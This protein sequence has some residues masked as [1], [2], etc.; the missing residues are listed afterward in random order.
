M[1][2]NAL[3]H[4]LMSR[5]RSAL[6]ARRGL[7]GNVDRLD[8][9]RAAGWVADQR[10][11][12]P[13]ELCLLVD[14]MPVASFR[15]ALAR[16]DVRAAGLAAGNCGFDQP[17]PDSLRD[18]R[19]HLVEIRVGPRG[20]LLPGGSLRVGTAAT[21]TAAATG[22]R[23]AIDWLSAD[24]VVGWVDAGTGTPA[25]VRLLIDGQPALTARADQPRDDVANSG[26]GG[27]ISGFAFTMPPAF[28]D[29]QPH[30]V[31]VIE[32]ETGQRLRGGKARLG[33]PFEGVA[34]FDP[35][36]RAIAGWAAG[37]LAVRVGF[38]DGPAQ[39]VPLNRE[40]PGFADGNRLGF[41][42]ELPETLADGMVH[43]ARV[44]FGSTP[45][46]LDGAPV[47]FR[48]LAGLPRV[49][50][51]RVDGRRAELRLTDARGRPVA[52]PVAIEVDGE[53]HSRAMAELS[54]PLVVALP[55][56]AT[57]LDLIEDAPD[58]R[59]S[60]AR[61]RIEERGGVAVLTPERDPAQALAADALDP[62]LCAAAAEALA[63]FGAD[64]GPRFDAGWYARRW[65]QA[66][67]QAGS[68]SPAALLAH[69]L[70][71]GGRDGLS[72]G[73]WFDE[74][75]ARR[76]YPVL[77]R[78]VAA[79]RL[80][81]AFAM[82]LILSPGALRSVPG[83]DPAAFP[84]LVDPQA[85][86]R[87]PGAALAAASPAIARQHPGGGPDAMLPPPSA[88]RRGADSIYAAWLQRLAIDDDARAALDAD[89]IAARAEIAALPLDR[90]PLVSIIMPTWNRAF[91][92]G[93]AVQSVIEQSYPD[94][95][96]LICD[97]ASADMTA[98]VVRGFD[99]PRIRYLQLSKSNGA[100]ARNRGLAFARG[101]YIA[102]LDSDNLWNPHF[103]D[104]MLRRLLAEPGR[105]LAYSAYLDTEIRGATVSLLQVARPA[106]KAVAL[107]RRNF[108]DLNSILHHRRLYDWIGGFDERLPRLQ[109]WDLV[110]R[111][112]GPF[113]PLM[114]DR[115]MVFYRRN[116]AWGQVTY[117]FQNSTAQDTVNEKAARRLD[118]GPPPLA[119][120]WPPGR[121][122]SLLAGTGADDR[123]LA[124]ALARLVPAGIGV[125]LVMPGAAA[126]PD[127][128]ASV[129]LH[130][131]PAALGDSPER[132]G[133][134]LGDL[135]REAPVLAAGPDP[136]TLG[137]IANG[138]ARA[139]ALTVGPAGLMLTA[140]AGGDPALAF[141]LGSLP[142]PLPQPA[143]ARRG[144]AAGAGAARRSGRRSR[145]AGPRRRRA[146]ASTCCCRRRAPAPAG[147]APAPTAATP[148]ARAWPPAPACRRLVG[149]VRLVAVA[150]RWRRCRRSTSRSWRRRCRPA[151]W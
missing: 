151:A 38:D 10:R 53:P 91:T 68:D 32:A 3:W 72:P 126:V 19:P 48:L 29:G 77:D 94:W 125:D 97:D 96:L 111:Y 34:F 98:E 86:A 139:L 141:P 146:P 67:A 14:G 114:V 127:L 65:P 89:E 57:L 54:Q 113:P 130:R 110:L 51:L 135:L 78:A 103:L 117:M 93:E 106:F 5:S 22:V 104:L 1:T 40:V 7:R 108:M 11:P 75:E 63:R 41:R 2:R 107:A 16:D 83:A 136:A 88:G 147:P 138:S 112:T 137:R 102:Y 129:R 31:E 116:L 46:A 45:M 4:R 55:R 60:L 25:S 18:G 35:E 80:P 81:C 140:A 74:A 84:G 131:P 52:L 105:A 61:F 70:A 133:H 123:G 30:D 128:P 13:V 82:E 145:P 134:G 122:V 33:V 79:G 56:G 12:D 43:R 120:D 28:H 144:A 69:Y 132:L 21:A 71:S 92:I 149:A 118:Q 148:P 49:E 124:E 142:L 101:D 15:A 9:R 150:D 99:D 66:V 50:L 90:R 73:P 44:T 39:T 85:L 76:L 47:S 36:R 119:V 24:R 58:D 121:R 17:L 6:L 8:D 100:G 37:C 26:L 87:D 95:E 42:L 23:G 20:P 59:R 115:A 109:D 64:P 62:A 143:T 27:R